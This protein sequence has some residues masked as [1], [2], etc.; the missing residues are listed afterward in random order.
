VARLTPE[1]ERALGDLLRRAQLGDQEAYDRL[2]RELAVLVRDFAARR[3]RALL[4]Q[5]D[6]VQDVLLTVH[7][8]RRTYDPARPLAPWFYAILQSRFADACRR[9]RRRAFWEVLT[10]GSAFDLR[11]STSSAPRHPRADEV[12]EALRDLPR[13]QRRI[14]QWLKLEDLSV[15]EIAKRL[16]MRESAVKVAAHRGYEAIRR[17]LGVRQRS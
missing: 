12:A 9:Q 14:I 1:T 4:S 8:V 6:L 16:R 7:R 2:L 13:A 15:R 17:R 5:E 10:D 3:S 11:S